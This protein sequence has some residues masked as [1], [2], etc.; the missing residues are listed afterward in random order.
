MIFSFYLLLEY[1]RT[2][3]VIVLILFLKED[4]IYLKK[5]CGITHKQAW[6]EEYVW[7]YTVIPNAEGN[8]IPI[9]C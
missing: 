3:R 8:A 7:E 5:K 2:E 6:G 4:W 1:K 9:Y